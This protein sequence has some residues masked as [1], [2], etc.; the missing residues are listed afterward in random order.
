MWYCTQRTDLKT[1]KFDWSFFR[2]CGSHDDGTNSLYY[3]L[4]LSLQLVQRNVLALVF[5]SLRS[6]QLL[7]AHKTLAPLIRSDQDS[8]LSTNAISVVEAPR[9]LLAGDQLDFNGTTLVTQPEHVEV[10]RRHLA[11]TYNILLVGDLIGINT[12]CLVVG[13]NNVIDLWRNVVVQT[14]FLQQLDDNAVTE[15]KASSG[16]FS[17]RAVQSQQTVVTTTSADGTQLDLHQ[18]LTWIYVTDT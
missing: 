9:D 16:D 10:S 13:N 4:T 2:T 3:E 15:A 5:L 6:T 1:T 18:M 17:L 12:H 14:L 8:S 7:D 11:R